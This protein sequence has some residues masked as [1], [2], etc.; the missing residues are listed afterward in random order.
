L[1]TPGP[2]EEE[3]KTYPDPPTLEKEREIHGK[4]EE[5]KSKPRNLRP[6]WWSQMYDRKTKNISDE[7]WMN[8]MK[9]PSASEL[10]KTIKQIPRDKAAGYDGVEINLIKLLT[11]DGESPLVTIL[12]LFKIAFTV[13]RTLPSWRK[14]VITMIPKRREDG[15]WTDKVKDMRPISVLQEF[16]KIAAKLLAE[17]W[18]NILLEHAHILNNA[19]RAFIKDGCV[20]QCISTALNVFEEKVKNYM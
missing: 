16:G 5:Q 4:T 7:T 2:E 9:E 3:Q 17:R 10:L 12:L 11:E 6:R 13:G 18:G 15:S 1:E 20:Q 19:Q 8:L 14:S